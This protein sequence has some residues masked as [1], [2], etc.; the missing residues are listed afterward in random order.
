MNI[1]VVDGRFCDAV[2]IPLMLSHYIG[3]QKR[4][5][6]QA[7]HQPLP[8]GGAVASN[9]VAGFSD[10]R[11]SGS[12]QTVESSKVDTLQREHAGLKGAT[13]WQS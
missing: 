2:V 13:W 7:Q 8:V 1:P 4:E 9:A 6:L 12:P 3:S 5:A 11:R 10:E